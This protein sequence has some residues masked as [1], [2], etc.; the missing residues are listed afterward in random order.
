MDAFGK[1][2]ACFAV[3]VVSACFATVLVAITVYIVR[4]VGG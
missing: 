1:L 4:A 3:V 2:V